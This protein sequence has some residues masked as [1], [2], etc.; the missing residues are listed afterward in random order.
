MS[1]IYASI[2]VGTNS[3]L[4]LIAKIEK[5][6]VSPEMQ[7]EPDISGKT[8]TLPAV[9]RQRL[10]PCLEK[11]ASVRLGEDL[12]AES[13]EITVGPQAQ[14][15]LIKA[16]LEFRQVIHNTGA[17]LMALTLTEAMRQATNQEDILHEFET[18]FE[19]HNIAPTILTGPEEALGSWV[20]VA[21]YYDKK[22]FVS[23]DIGAGSTELSTKEHRVS[24]PL[25]ALR[26]NKA[27][28]AVPGDSIRDWLI[29]QTEEVEWENYK[30]LPIYLCGG[31]A[32]ALAAVSLKLDY[33]DGKA[34]ESY[35]V[36]YGLVKR[37]FMRLGDL[38]AEVRNKIPGLDKG[39]GDLI[40]PGLRILE[41][42]IEK[43]NPDVCRVTNLGLRYGIL[44]QL[45]SQQNLLESP[46]ENQ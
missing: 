21:H 5:H 43:L 39:R 34:V 45:L 44:V 2:D 15:R 14:S 28:G 27:Y 4:L 18:I 11:L 35:P 3:A 22:E 10:E 42:Y 36:D 40:I 25:G 38:S 24:M 7:S 6:I 41:N 29:G 17:K 16:M 31:T 19:L 46:L 30:G 20:G 33:F 37:T 12:K 26:I 13:E 9:T 1:E 23:L 8:K 32:T